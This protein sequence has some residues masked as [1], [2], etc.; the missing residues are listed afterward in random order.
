M[1]YVA[2]IPAR[3]RST[4]LPDKPLAD[5]AGKPMIVRVAERVAQAG[6]SRA[7]VATDDIRILEAVKAAGHEAIMTRADHPSGT[8]RLAE[9]ADIL[10]LADDT[11]VINVQGDE[12]LIDPV[13]LDDVAAMLRADT[14]L[15]MATACHPLTDPQDFFF[16]PNVVKVVLDKKNQRALYFSRA[17]VA[18]ARDAFAQ[19]RNVLPDDFFCR[20]AIS[21]CT[22]I[23][24]VS[25]V[26]TTS[27]HH[28]RWS[29]GR[30]WN[31]CACYG[32]VTPSACMLHRTHRPPVS[33]P[34]KTWNGSARYTRR[35]RRLCRFRLPYADRPLARSARTPSRQGKARG[36][37]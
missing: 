15:P 9:A 2:L 37:I 32:M 14:A 33:I 4:R 1:S 31:N 36:L 29:I 13:L 35:P 6:A 18:W 23:A 26:F 7:V 30:R 5:I 24:P 11:I 3:M 34:S 8:D 12:P 10:Q 27:W 17:P 21:V 20:Y 25:C 22:V 19:G 28:R 16:N